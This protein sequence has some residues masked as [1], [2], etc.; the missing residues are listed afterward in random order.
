MGLAAMTPGTL[1]GSSPTANLAGV[2]FKG[3]W[4]V[5]ISLRL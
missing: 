1:N 2:N 4:I 5:S 3:K